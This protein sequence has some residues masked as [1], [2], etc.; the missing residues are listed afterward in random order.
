MSISKVVTS[1]CG[2]VEAQFGK[3]SLELESIRAYVKKMRSIKVPKVTKD[4]TAGLETKTI[5][6]SE[7]SFGSLI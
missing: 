7:Q 4:L 2:A 1:I 6:R 3:D 5:S